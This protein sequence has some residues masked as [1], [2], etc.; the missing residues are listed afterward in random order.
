M[1][2]QPKDFCPN[3]LVTSGQATLT[4]YYVIE[5]L[6]FSTGAVEKFLTDVEINVFLQLSPVTWTEVLAMLKESVQ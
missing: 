3:C 1:R 2:L 5:E 6:L 4:L